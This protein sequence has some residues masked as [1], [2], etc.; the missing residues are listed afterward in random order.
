MNLG[1]LGD[2][3][4]L[5]KEVVVLF[6]PTAGVF[7]FNFMFDS[8]ITGYLLRSTDAFFRSIFTAVLA[9]P[10]SIDRLCS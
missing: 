7:G 2:L 6:F 9:F 10:A 3:V 5:K 4:E 1:L 8:K